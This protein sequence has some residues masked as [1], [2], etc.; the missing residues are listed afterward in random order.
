[1]INNSPL[2]SVIVISYNS[3]EYIVETL[4]SIKNQLYEN[5]ELI[6]SDDTSTDNTIAICEQ[7]NEENKH[8]FISTK[9]VQ[10]T[11][12]T[13]LSANINRG[14][15]VAKGKWIKL[16]AGDDLLTENCI[17]ENIDYIKKHND[18]DIN[19][20]FSIRANFQ[21]INGKKEIQNQ[22]ENSIFYESNISCE[23]Q[24]ELALRGFNCPPNTLFISKVALDTIG[25]CDED[26]PMY[27]DTPL[28]LRLLKQNYKFYYMPAVTFLYR[29][30][31]SSIYHSDIQKLNYRPWYY[32]SYLP[33]YKKY[34]Y[35][36]ITTLEKIEFKYRVFIANLFKVISM[37]NNRNFFS[38]LL[39][40]LLRFPAEMINKYNRKR[41]VKKVA[42][43]I[44]TLL[45]GNNLA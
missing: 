41:I 27:E 40:Y 19:V 12:N 11:K 3:S 7:W 18:L 44:N 4:E 1:M 29:I 24:Y 28:I 38:R 31:L 42:N 10:V 33:V 6:I 45:S 43:N 21:V 25:G 32:N 22:F 26:Y 14:L 16:I 23:D 30:H 17:K 34:R 37:L 39:N 20:I 8:R 2:V 13:G 5:I 9:V 35:P 15:K 36:Y